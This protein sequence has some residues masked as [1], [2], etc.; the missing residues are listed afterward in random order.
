MGLMNGVTVF[1]WDPRI[2]G[3]SGIGRLADREFDHDH[4]LCAVLSA[5]VVGISIAMQQMMIR[6]VPYAS[7]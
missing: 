5:G 6:S 3:V 4:A 7:S 2:D 1:C